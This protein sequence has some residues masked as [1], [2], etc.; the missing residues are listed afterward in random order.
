MR[1]KQAPLGG[2][3]R[4]ARNDGGRE[5]AEEPVLGEFGGD[6]E[7]HGVAPA[8]EVDE[9]ADERR[10][11]RA[12]DEGHT[13]RFVPA[14][15]EDSG[16]HEQPGRATLHLGNVALDGGDAG[17]L[18]HG[19]GVGKGAQSLAGDDSAGEIEAKHAL[20]RIGAEGEHRFLHPRGHRGIERE[21]GKYVLGNE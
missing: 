3:A 5:V 18:G 17:S 8:A 10:L 16:E 12:A 7:A 19:E 2:K 1:R 6:E 11:Y 14:R 20:G 15:G 4:G 13:H 9:A 21:C